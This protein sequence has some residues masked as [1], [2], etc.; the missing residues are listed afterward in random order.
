MMLS[1]PQ[2]HPTRAPH[3]ATIPPSLLATVLNTQ[4][5]RSTAGATYLVSETLVYADTLIAIHWTIIIT[6]EARSTVTA[7]RH[8]TLCG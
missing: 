1:P 2:R 8:A 6:G 7:A 5:I 4:V 3:I